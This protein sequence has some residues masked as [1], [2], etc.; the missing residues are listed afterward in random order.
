MRSVYLDYNATTPLAP[1]VLDAMLPYLREAFGNANSVHGFGQRAR[2]AV[3]QAREQVAT[4]VGAEPAEIAFTSG[5]TEANN[6]AIFGAVGAAPGTIKHVITSATEHVAV[7]D[8]VREL[9]RRGA[10]VTR[11]PVNRDGLV[12]PED[13]HRAI[14]VET[15]LISIMLANNEIGVLEPIEQIGQIAAEKGIVLHTDA[16]QAA[17]KVPIDVQK[18]GVHLLSLSAHKLYGPKGVGALCIRK[19]T[20]LERLLY[21]GHHERDH[22]PGTE[23]VAGIVG[24]GCAADLVWSHLLEDGERIA[25]LRYRLERELLKRVPGARVNARGASRVPNTTSVTFPFVEGEAIVIALDLK[26]IACSTGAA[27]SSGAVEP[28]HVLTAMGVSRE[29]ARSTVRFSLG[30]DTTREGIDYALETIP[31]VIARLR[32]LLPASSKPVDSMKTFPRR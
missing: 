1:E 26:G 16:V 21:G 24:F 2:G 12:A 10:S 22:R 19:G 31:P 14:R 8:P 27:C 13:V 18:L 20:R 28:S 4:L 23:N 29:D 32:E 25:A 15:V 17:G 7:L 3:E 11:L 5:G 6:H 30:R 9:E